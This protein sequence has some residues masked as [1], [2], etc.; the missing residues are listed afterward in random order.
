M[1]EEVR[2]RRVR[3]GVAGNRLVGFRGPRLQRELVQPEAR[4]AQGFAG[5]DQLAAY[6]QA[7]DAHFI[8]GNREWWRDG[9]LGVPEQAQAIQ[10][11]ID[12]AQADVPPAPPPPNQD[13]A[14]HYAAQAPSSEA[15][16]EDSMAQK[17]ANPFSVGCDPEFMILRGNV[18]I[19]VETTLGITHTGDVGSDHNGLVVEVHPQPARGTY[20]IL[21]R[22]Q[23]ILLTNKNLKLALDKKWRAGAAFKI[24]NGNMGGRL[25]TLGGHVHLDLPPMG[26]G[27]TVENHN[28]RLNALDRVT[29]YLEFLDILPKVESETRRAE[30]QRLGGNA[31]YGKWGDWRQAGGEDGRT[32]VRLEYRT[33]ASWLYDP[34]AAYLVLTGAKL[35]ALAPQIAVDTLKVRNINYANLQ[36]FFDLFKFKDINARRAVDG[37]LTSTVAQLQ[38]VP[39]RDV[40]TAWESL[41]V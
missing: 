29:K 21:K 38:A 25:M 37:I 27:E 9:V 24:D 23:T 4:P 6:R 14:A 17:L 28:L 13:L 31:A 15:T 19:N 26:H 34:R 30:G 36:K 33:P 35:A 7:R 3:P 22:I 39:D 12:R 5:V 20:T 11:G 10:W 16:F 18:P 8:P 1:P 32:K 40:K 41:N 2:P